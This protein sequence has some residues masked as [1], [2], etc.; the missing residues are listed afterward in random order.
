[1]IDNRNG[2]GISAADRFFR[3]DFRDIAR[4]YPARLAKRKKHLNVKRVDLRYR[5]EVRLVEGIFSRPQCPRNNNAV[6]RAANRALIKNFACSRHF[7]L[8]ELQV[9]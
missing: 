1:M 2:R 5:N 7:K 3:I 9:D 8:G 4:T 6:Y